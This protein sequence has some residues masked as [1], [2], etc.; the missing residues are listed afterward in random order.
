M[1]RSESP[2]GRMGRPEELAGLVAYLLSEDAQ[3]TTGTSI[4]YNGG[5]FMA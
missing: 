2:V 3:G 4:D 5:A 1:D